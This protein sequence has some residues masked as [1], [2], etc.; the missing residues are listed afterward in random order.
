MEREFALVL[1]EAEKPQEAG[2][3]SCFNLLA[4]IPN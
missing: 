3:K 2:E 4:Q 1:E